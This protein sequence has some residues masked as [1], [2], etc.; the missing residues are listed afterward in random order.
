MYMYSSV[1]VLD[2]VYP[3][4]FVNEDHTIYMTTSVC[5]CTRMSE[6]VMLTI[7]M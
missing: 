6:K 4:L 3:T 1:I 7:Y 5:L 2:Q